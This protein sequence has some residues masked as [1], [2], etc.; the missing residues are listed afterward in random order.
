VT[1]VAAYAG[2]VS[3]VLPEPLALAVLIALLVLVPTAERLAPRVA[4]NISLV[5]GWTPVVWWVDWPG[6][7][8][9][10][11]VLLAT[12]AAA[13][14]FLVAASGQPRRRAR[15]A[16]PL[17]RPSDL[18]LAAGAG[19]AALATAP[20][21]LAATSA[22]A[23]AVLVPGADNYA[24]FNM[25]AT[26]RAYGATSDAL[27]AG[28][29]GSGW[30]FATYPQGF[31]AVVATI[32]E[33]TFPQLETGP[34]S[35]L[36]YAHTVAAVVVL[37]VVLVTASVLSLPGVGARPAVAFPALALAWTAL[38]WEPGQKVLANGFASFWLAAVA[39]GCALVLAFGLPA[40][41][42]K[43]GVAAVGGLLVCVAHSWMPLLFVAAP[44]A[45]VVLV[46]HDS[47]SLR[48]VVSR[49]QLP[50]LLI[51]GLSALAVG[52]AVLILLGKVEVSFIVSEV[53]GF[54]GTSALPTFVLLV[55]VVYLLL[56]YRGWVRSRGGTSID[57]VTSRRLAALVLSPVL[58]V[59]SLATLLV[60]QL[61]A[62]GTTSYY[63]LKYL[64]GFELIL[65][66]VAPALCVAL[67]VAVSGPARRPARALG[68]SV[69]AAVL[70]TLLF[71]PFGSALLWDDDDD[72]TASV[73]APYTREGIALGV[74][75][76]SRSTTPAG[77]FHREYLALGD[78]NAAQIFYP[79]GWFHA[80]N[81]SLTNRA[82]ARLNVLR[83]NVETAREA[84]PLVRRL[85]DDE[86]GLVVAVD[87]AYLEDLRRGLG[88]GDLARR[89]VPIGRTGG[90]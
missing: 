14:G 4:L 59:G 38:L 28:P 32:S 12:V 10:A 65:T 25:F 29:D 5:L 40:A 19:V 34:D 47:R 58:A 3:A 67:V 18:L 55:T 11:G 86:P 15:A 69:L 80:M 37:G 54:D 79:G 45:L 49:A 81:A 35:V 72:G 9:H 77:S 71:A 36:V 53:S 6:G 17:L 24:H 89:V 75:A 61:R 1:G 56:G 39:A 22:R 41:P 20:L 31:H 64:L 78:G 7:V 51:L 63:F 70:A 8:N 83:V 44:A 52:R 60:L 74:L 13:G 43:A 42:T 68:V 48:S 62:I 85:L 50:T 66:V 84:A 57:A 27:G 16:L 82:F 23:L 90:R 46:P 2:V 21:L 30:A 87:P 88:P 26:M 73:V 76:A 33:L